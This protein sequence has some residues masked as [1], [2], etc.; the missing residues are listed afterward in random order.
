M[1]SLTISNDESQ[2]WVLA[3][4][5]EEAGEEFGLFPKM[6]M[7]LNLVLEEVVSNCIFYAYPGQTGRDIVVEIECSDGELRVVVTDWGIAFD[8]TGKED[9]DVSLKAE[10]R[11]IG[12]LGIFLVRKVMDRVC[13]ERKEGKNVL[14]MAK[15]LG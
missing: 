2:L 15:K 14:V 11:A 1:K 12:G 8:P 6:I 13:Y 4:F 5:I 10:D 3:G 7:E 9:P